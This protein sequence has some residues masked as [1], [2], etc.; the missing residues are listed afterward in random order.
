MLNNLQY[1]IFI[2]NDNLFIKINFTGEQ[3]KKEIILDSIQD[4][5]FDGNRKYIKSDFKKNLKRINYEIETFFNEK[6]FTLK[7]IKQ[8]TYI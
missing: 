8:A 5:R 6:R 4:A 7:P 3:M 1:F 2:E